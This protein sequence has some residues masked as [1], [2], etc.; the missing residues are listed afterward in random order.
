MVGPGSEVDPGLLPHSYRDTWDRDDVLVQTG[1][2][3]SSPGSVTEL[4][5][6][7]STSFHRDT[8]RPTDV[9]G[10][11]GSSVWTCDSGSYENSDRMGV[12]PVATHQRFP[13][14]NT[15]LLSLLYPLSR[16]IYRR[17]DRE[18]KGVL[19]VFL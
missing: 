17:R 2:T 12:N 8:P 14:I 11:V 6:C 13:T 7:V 3:L 9:L 19:L 1:H 16:D 5:R 18:T 15:L 4:R 10:R